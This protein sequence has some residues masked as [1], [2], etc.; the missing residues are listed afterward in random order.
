[1]AFF[2]WA[3]GENLTCAGVTALG[4]I[5]GGFVGAAGAGVTCWATLTALGFFLPDFNDNC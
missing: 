4:G 5:A 3:A 2:S 1:M